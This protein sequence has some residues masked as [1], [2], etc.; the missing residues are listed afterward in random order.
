MYFFQKN[1]LQIFPLDGNIRHES[2]S[3]SSSEMIRQVNE[4]DAL[5]T[6]RSEPCFEAPREQ[7]ESLLLFELQDL[8]TTLV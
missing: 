8:A 5:L 7:R 1:S 3:H 4:H 2:A 6:S